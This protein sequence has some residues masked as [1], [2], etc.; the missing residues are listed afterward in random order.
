MCK[1]LRA[2]RPE[3][4][5]LEAGI[6]ITAARE[7]DYYLTTES[8]WNT[9]SKEEA[10]HMTRVTDGRIEVQR[11]IK[12]PLLDINAVMSKHFGRRADVPLDRRGGV[13]PGH[14]EK[15]RLQ[16][17]P[18]R[19]DLCRDLGRR[20]AAAGSRNSRVH[21]DAEVRRPGGLVRQHNLRRRQPD[22][23]EEQWAAALVAS[24]SSIAQL[25]N[26]IPIGVPAH[27]SGCGGSLMAMAVLSVTS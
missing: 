23:I 26:S 9:F 25:P 6:G 21:G 13:A 3:D 12:M 18:S 14:P 22:L 1:K 5:T 8:A 24:E 7:A 10:E 15:H 27:S 16:A 19:G 4:T 17:V 11:V 20:D 2:V